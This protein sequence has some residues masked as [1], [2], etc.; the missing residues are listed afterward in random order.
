MP[1]R[2]GYR[3]YYKRPYRSSYRSRAVSRWRGR[4]RFGYRPRMSRAIK[5]SPQGTAFPK[6][7]IVKL[8]YVENV[9][10]DPGAVAFAEFAYRANSIFDPNLTGGGHQPMGRD[11]WATF[12]RR[13]TVIGSKIQVQCVCPTAS[14]PSIF[15]VTLSDLSATGHTTVHGLMERPTTSWRFMSTST[16]VQPKHAS[17]KF[18]AKKFF[19]L[20]N[21]K[22]NQDRVGADFTADPSVEA[23]FHCFLGAHDATTNLPLHYFTIKITY[24]VLM[25]HPKE[26]AQS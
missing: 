16:A 11:Q 6:N 10:L 26:L 21:I 20:A 9:T 15:G 13:Y 12:Y 23:Y 17:C 4:G 8:R 5:T 25:S 18:S 22:D 1:F 14:T 24:I 7:R 2:R 19:N 3:R